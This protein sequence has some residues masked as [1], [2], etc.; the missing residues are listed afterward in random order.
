MSDYFESDTKSPVNIESS[1]YKLL[2]YCNLKLHNAD[3]LIGRFSLLPDIENA[4][5]AK[6][7]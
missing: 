2:H 1:K 4:N 5:D 3:N 6:D 7:I